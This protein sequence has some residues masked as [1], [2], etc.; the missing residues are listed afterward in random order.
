M[1]CTIIIPTYNE[2]G[3]IEKTIR[4]LET[5]FLS[6]PQ[7]EM[8]I[9]VFDSNSTDPTRSIVQQL[10][11]QWP[12]IYLTGEEKKSGLG[13]AYIQAMRYATDV[14]KADVVFE[15]DADG[16][17][18]P[19]H[20][21]EMIAL[22]QAGNDVVVG[23]RYVKGGK[24]AVD[25]PWYRRLISVAGNWTA[26]L[27]LTPRYKDF[28]SGFRAT[29]TIWLKKI[30][31]EGLLSRQYA[32]KIHLFWALHK[33]G[34]KIVESPI[35]FI[36]RTEGESK[37]PR[38]NTTDSLNVVIKLRLSEMQ[39]YFKVTACGL[40]GFIAQIITFNLL[41]LFLHPTFANAIAVECAIILNFI[42][43]NYI[44]FKDNS[45]KWQ[46]CKK[47][48]FKKLL[49][50]NGCSLISLVLQLLVMHFG[51]IIFGHSFVIYNIL[52]LAGIILGSIANYFAY[53][54]IVWRNPSN[55]RKN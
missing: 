35:E 2:S 11:K 47:T 1:R 10:Q 43:N 34:A 27:F 7:I 19:K 30:D 8:N 49:Q 23:S 45:A 14:L 5:T 36:D 50:F 13:G 20:I 32:Y 41:V 12:N 29:K 39:R 40:V 22:L 37:F 38:R 46:E 21:P 53:H 26:R 28:T 54:Y 33:A 15:F 16:S 52:L 24:I 55:E 3:T 42:I 48:F 18:Q 25:W 6:L 31:L 9:L 51:A 44:T 17:H 4:E